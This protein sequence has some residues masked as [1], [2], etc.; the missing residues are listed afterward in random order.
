MNDEGTRHLLCIFRGNGDVPEPG[1][2]AGLEHNAAE[3]ILGLGDDL[4]DGLHGVFDGGEEGDAGGVPHQGRLS[5][6]RLYVARRHA[7]QTQYRGSVLRIRDTK[8]DVFLT[9]R[10]GKG[11][12]SGS[13][14]RIL[15]EQ[16]GSYFRGA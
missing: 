14:I 7:W 1:L 15:D 16:P 4:L 5:Q 3:R 2:Q 9:P 12:N 13:G 6:P 8:S 10:P 11:K